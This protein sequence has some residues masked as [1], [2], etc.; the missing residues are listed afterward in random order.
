MQ[1][2]IKKQ[3]H[4]E[5]TTEEI[6]TAILHSKLSGF[7]KL[8]VNFTGGEVLGNREDVFEILKYTQSLGIKYR[9]NINSWW[10]NQENFTIGGKYFKSGLHLA[11]YIKSLGIEMFAF[12]CDTRH[13]NIANQRNLISTIK[14]CEQLG[15]NDQL[16]FT[17]VQHSQIKAILLTLQKICGTLRHII[18]VSMQ[19]VDIG[20]GANVS[21]RIFSCQ[22]NKAYCNKKGFYRPTTLHVSPDGN[23]RTC[24]YALGLNNCGNLR[25]TSMMDIAEKN[26]DSIFSN[27]VSFD[28]FEKEKLL[29]YQ[30]Y[31]RSTIHEC[32]RL[33][34]LARTAEMTAKNPKMS[35]DDIHKRI[36]GEI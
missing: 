2:K 3:N 10:G 1:K 27:P 32:T 8:G 20:G 31:Y 13:F 7:C 23:V 14:I 33:V 15:I 19:M 24:M 21:K 11:D 34:I 30:H 35:L 6:K 26:K 18:P 29:P 25:E 36:A 12:S 9:L 17:G 4:S 22:S 5:L 28:N 16:I